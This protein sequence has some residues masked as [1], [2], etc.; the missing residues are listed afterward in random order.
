MLIPEDGVYE[1]WNERAMEKALLTATKI[2]GL[3]RKI[4]GIK[5]IFFGRM[6]VS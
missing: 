4:C 3:E 6:E 1:D 5:S 2:E